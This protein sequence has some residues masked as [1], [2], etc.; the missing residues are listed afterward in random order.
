MGGTLFD[1]LGFY[2]VG[3]INGHDF[4]Q[5]IPVL[6]NVRD[7]SHKGPFLVHAITQKGKRL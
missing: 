2:Y 5:L 3:T 1:E 6:K 7:S 4:D